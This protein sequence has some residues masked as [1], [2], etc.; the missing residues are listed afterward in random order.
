MLYING[1]AGFFKIR[2][3]VRNLK[4]LVR[5]LRTSPESDVRNLTVLTSNGHEV[6]GLIPQYTQSHPRSTHDAPCDQFW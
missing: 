6:Q 2:L 5:N 1:M 3:E 4:I